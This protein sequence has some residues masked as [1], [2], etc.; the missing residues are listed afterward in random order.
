MALRLIA[1]A[2]PPTTLLM[3]DDDDPPGELAVT[4]TLALPL[5]FTALPAGFLTPLPAAAALPLS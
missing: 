2:A 5:A 3:G 1:A 4:T